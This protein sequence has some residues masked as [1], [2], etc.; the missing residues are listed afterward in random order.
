MNIKKFI[1]VAILV[2]FFLP[3]FVYYCKFGSL[4]L[5]ADIKDWVSFA[6]Y[7]TGI[8]TPLMAT[9]SAI[10]LYFTWQNTKKELD[11]AKYKVYENFI[12]FRLEKIN[13]FSSETFN[14]NETFT[15]N[16]KASPLYPVGDLSGTVSHLKLYKFYFHP[17]KTGEHRLLHDIAINNE[18]FSSLKNLF[19]PVRKILNKINNE[20]EY[21]S[22]IQ[23]YVFFSIPIELLFMAIFLYHKNLENAELDENKRTDFEICKQELVSVIKRNESEIKIALYISDKEMLQLFK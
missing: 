1:P 8:L 21:K 13:E 11:L 10:F 19:L 4:R 23:L 22:H 20:S 3:I 16:C 7:F 9:V 5:S 2:M 18:K 17:A 12:N 6:D 14:T 15:S